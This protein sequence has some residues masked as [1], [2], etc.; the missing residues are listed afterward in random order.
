MT[1]LVPVVTLDPVVETK[2]T[3]L[4]DMAR[5]VA[6][7]GISTREQADACVRLLD[8]V[9]V[10][11]AEIESAFAASVA[12]AHDAHKQILAVRNGHTDVLDEAGKLIRASLNRYLETH[13]DEHVANVQPRSAWEFRVVDL[14][15]VPR[16]Y[17]MVDEKKVAKVVKALK[18]DTSIPGI[19]AYEVVTF[20]LKGA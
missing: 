13:R 10:M 3:R 18:A 6:Q 17:L 7:Q 11:S 15:A 8:T 20:A 2:A 16:E 4:L 9:K 5:T 1:T 14:A 12:A 19:E